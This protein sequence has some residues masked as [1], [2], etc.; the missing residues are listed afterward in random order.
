[1]SMLTR[2]YDADHINL[3]FSGVARGEAAIRD[4]V[5]SLPMSAF[6]FDYDYNA[7]T[8]EYLLQ[9]HK[10]FYEAVRKTHPD[11][12][13]LM[14]GHPEF[15]SNEMVVKRNAVVKETF[16]C[17]VASG[18]KNVYYIHSSELFRLCEDGGTVDGV[19]PTD[20]GFRSMASAMAKILDKIFE[21]KSEQF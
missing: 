7:P 5:A 11:I 10:P 17:A 20:F 13:I 14:M 12:P 3:G 9:T 6:I 16:D 1:M 19:H 15:Y 2:R 18:D 4:C 21:V 8:P